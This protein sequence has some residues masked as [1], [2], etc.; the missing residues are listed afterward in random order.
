MRVSCVVRVCARIF[1]DACVNVY[2]RAQERLCSAYICTVSA[3]ACV[4]I[5][6]VGICARAFLFVGMLMC[7]LCVRGV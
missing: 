5:F 4:C 7:M 6:K 1:Y 3:S 2:S